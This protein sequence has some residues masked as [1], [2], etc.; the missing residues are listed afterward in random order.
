VKWQKLYALRVDPAA[1]DNVILYQLERP[2]DP[3]QSPLRRKPHLVI[4]PEDSSMNIR[5]KIAGQSNMR[6]IPISRLETFIAAI[7]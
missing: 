4:H 7:K 6:D 2:D 5:F 1:P 3:S